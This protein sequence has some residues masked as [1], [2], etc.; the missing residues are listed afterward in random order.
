MLRRG[1]NAVDAGRDPQAAL[2]TPR[3][4]WHAGR[5]LL[6]E[7]DLDPEVVA[8]LRSRGHEVTV[9]AEPSVFGYGQAIRRAPGGGVRG[10][11]GVPRRRRDAGL[12]IRR[13]PAP[14]R[15]SGRRAGWCRPVG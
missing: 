3:W 10:R 9:A 12:V 15:S 13:R 1:G 14:G 2:D 7:P 5:T 6:V 11:V 4:H 8:G